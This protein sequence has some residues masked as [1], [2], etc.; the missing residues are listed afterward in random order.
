M[1]KVELR[2]LELSIQGLGNTASSA[3]L[4]IHEALDREPGGGGEANKKGGYGGETQ[5]ALAGS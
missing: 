5:K 2:I 4:S 1:Y 3:C